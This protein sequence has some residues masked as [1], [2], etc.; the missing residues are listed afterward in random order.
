MQPKIS[1]QGTQMA[2]KFPRKVSRK[3]KI[4]LNFLK[5]KISVYFA[6]LSSIIE[7]PENGV[8]FVTGIF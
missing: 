5:S 4:L 2:P 3:P 8:L 6:R 7:N 1:K